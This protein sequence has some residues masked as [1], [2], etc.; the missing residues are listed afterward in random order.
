MTRYISYRGMG[1]G[2]RVE[3][4][5]DVNINIILVEILGNGLFVFLFSNAHLC[6]EY[7]LP[8]FFFFFCVL[9]KC[10]ASLTDQMIPHSI[11]PKRERCLNPVLFK[12][13]G[14]QGEYVRVPFGRCIRSKTAAVFARLQLF[15]ALAAL[16]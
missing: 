1:R 6:I 3:I 7:F 16:G 13:L 8:P 10:L 9:N 12:S 5:L 4:V 14:A 2:Q 15:S 11:T